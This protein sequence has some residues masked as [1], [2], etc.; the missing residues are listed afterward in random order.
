MNKFKESLIKVYQSERGVLVLMILN[1]LISIVLMIF[2]FTK[3]NPNSSSIKIGYG[4]IGGYRDGSWT[5]TLGFAIAA[6]LFGGLHNLLAL[7]IYE[8]RGGGMAKFFLLTT[9][10]LI[11]GTFV[12]LIRLSREW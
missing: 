5:N 1:L 12:V 7:R 10:M 4:D 2:T 9:T 3:L 11:M 8:K 6:I